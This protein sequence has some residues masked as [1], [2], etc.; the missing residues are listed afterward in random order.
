VAADREQAQAVVV[1]ELV[2]ADVTVE[3]PPCPP[4]P[5]P[6]LG[7]PACSSRT[8]PSRANRAAASGRS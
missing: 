5:C 3:G 7:R 1:G 8:R 4:W 6:F 2:E